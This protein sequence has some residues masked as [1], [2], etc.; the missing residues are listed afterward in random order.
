[1]QVR[2]ASAVI[3]RV[4]SVY[5]WWLVP[6]SLVLGCLLRTRE[7]LFDK[8]LWLDELAITTNLTRRS[9]A[10]LIQPLAG[11]QGGPLGWLWA[12]KASISLFGVHELALRLPAWVASLV[13]LRV[14]P[15]VA[16]R[17][18]GPIATP[19]ATFL[20]ATSPVLIFYSAETKQY[21]SDTACALLAILVTTSLIDRSP[22]S[23]SALMW[24]LATGLL[25]WFS[26]PAIL[27]VGA[28]AAV[29]VLRW[30]TDRAALARL[31][32]GVVVLTVSL[33]VEYLSTLR[34]LAANESLEAYWQAYGGYPPAGATSIGLVRWVVRA[35]TTLSQSFAQFAVPSL[36]CVLALAGLAI[37]FRQHPMRATLLLLVMLAAMA[38]AVTKHYPLAQRLALYLVPILIML[39][40]TSLQIAHPAS[41]DRQRPGPRPSQFFPV[42]LVVVVLM[43]ISA[44]AVVAGVSKLW[45]PDETEAGRQ[46]V[47]FVADHQLPSDAVV[48]DDWGRSALGFYGER[49]GVRQTGTVA[50]RSPHGRPC[51]E[52]QFASLA[53]RQ[54]VWLVLVHHPSNEPPDRN[55]VY[56][57]RFSAPATLLLSY[58]G[59]GDVA[60]YLYDLR[61]PPTT[62]VKPIA[63]WLH[64]GCFT[65]E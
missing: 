47:Q 24:G 16:R 40:C 23:R 44:P 36:T 39:L 1:M 61:Q 19:A 8:S 33:A 43:T 65:L 11:N 2:P 59:P 62:H 38:A 46:A 9:L 28:C 51:A 32:V 22:T 4:V 27:V 60:A 57:S 63:S 30:I 3:A 48:T 14:F 17:L 53:G 31:A 50:M 49:F 13:A 18:I 21:S 55:V 6:A 26:Q 12:E 35:S 20:V 25:A 56:A 42:A 10:G 15:V 7:W 5:R 64:D 34:Q 29:L 52:N 58:H 45:R 54:R 37:A 41:T